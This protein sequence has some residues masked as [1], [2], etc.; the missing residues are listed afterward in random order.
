MSSG[1]ALLSYLSG[2][3][4]LPSGP[5]KVVRGRQSLGDPLSPDPGCPAESFGLAA[6]GI[7]PKQ[8]LN[9]LP[10]SVNLLGDYTQRLLEIFN[11]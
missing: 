5:L 11:K 10:G 1:L 2:N 3:S 6:G 7:T 8:S 9:P 4:G